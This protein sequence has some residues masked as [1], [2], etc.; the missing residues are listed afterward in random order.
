MTALKV[1]IDG[2]EHLLD[3]YKDDPINLKLQY[4]NIEKIQS[5]VGTFSQ[6]FRIPAS[7]RNIAAFGNFKSTTEVGGINVKQKIEAWIEV[8]TIPVVSGFLQLNEAIV[9]NNEQFDFKLTFFGQNTDFFKALGDAK[10]TDLDFTSENYVLNYANYLNGQ[11]G[12]LSSGAIRHALMD[13][14]RIP[15]NN[16]VIGLQL[17]ED[18]PI[19]MSDLV[20]IVRTREIVQKIIAFAGYTLPANTFIDDDLFDDIYTAAFNGSPYPLPTSELSL[21]NEKFYVGLTA[22]ESGSASSVTPY[23]IQNMAQVGTGYYGDFYD[24]SDMYDVGGTPVAFTVPVGGLYT[25]SGYATLESISGGATVGW[26]ALYD[27]DNNEWVDPSTTI[28]PTNNISSNQLQLQ[29][30]TQYTLEQGVNYNLAIRFNTASATTFNLTTNGFGTG[31]AVQL[32]YINSG[33]TVDVA[34]NL[35]DYK[36]VDFIRDLQ[37][38]FNLVF[39]PDNNNAKEIN[40]KTFNGYQEGGEVKDWSDYVDYD[41]DYTIKPTANLQARDYLFSYT[42]GN[43]FANQYWV[44]TIGKTYGQYTIEDTEN[45]FATSKIDLVSGHQPLTL[46]RITDT[47]MVIHKAVTDDGNIVRKPKP[48]IGFYDAHEIGGDSNLD[49]L[50]G[51]FINNAGT[52]RQVNIFPFYGHPERMNPPTNNQDLNFGFEALTYGSTAPSNNLYTVYWQD[53]VNELYS[54]EARIAEYEIYLTPAQIADFKWNDNIFIKDDYW[55]VLSIDYSPNSASTSKVKLIKR[56]A[57]FRACEFIPDSQNS[58]NQIIFL[59]VDDAESVGNELCCN[60][61]G[62]NWFNSACFAPAPIGELVNPVNQPTGTGTT[63]GGGNEVITVAD[64][65]TV[66]TGTTVLA[67]PSISDLTISLPSADLNLGKTVTVVRLAGE[68]VLTV[69]SVVGTDTIN[70]ATSEDLIGLN[71]VVNYQSIGGGE[72]I[73]MSNAGPGSNNIYTAD[74]II[75]GETRFVDGNAASL[76]FRMFNTDVDT[77]TNTGSFFLS[78]SGTTWSLNNSGFGYSLTMTSFG[79]LIQDTST[80]QEGFKYADDYTGNFVTRSLVDKGY[81]DNIILVPTTIVTVSNTYTASVDECVI[82]TGA[83]S[84]TITLPLASLS[85]G[86]RV[87]IKKMTGGGTTTVDGNGADTI[88]GSATVTLSTNYESLTVLSTGSEWVII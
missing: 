10:L 6:S 78:P 19:E 75:D 17:N 47:G 11:N 43:D 69:D 32:V 68:N 37:V 67:D 58:D 36:L 54:N 50:G 87:I 70:G 27:V 81:V 33:Q 13:K 28:G 29:G 52:T 82:S 83:I 86:K 60:Y 4:S 88:D 16:S 56:L 26:L 8:D 24:T 2:T 25:V 71:T 42:P 55:R 46:S 61:Y 57:A 84:Y 49:N 62:Y 35:P 31:L 76:V 64:S 7:D 80:T 74:G 41:K 72:W 40:I 63:T 12:T 15:W 53:Y 22:T 18:N 20:P 39:I 30:E 65:L 5:A 73:E 3:T 79:F 14:G 48:M 38:Q 44:K 85:E 23:Y 9:H 51:L 66:N 1:I 59:D 21:D 45:D 77:A 34:R